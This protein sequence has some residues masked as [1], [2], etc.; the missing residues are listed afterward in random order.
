MSKK[1]IVITGSAGQL[2]QY[3]VQYFSSDV[4]KGNLDIYNTVGFDKKDVDIEDYVKVQKYFD[5]VK[6]MC[7]GD[8]Y[9]IHCAAATDTAAIE[10]DP[11]KFYSTNCLGAKN[12]A[13][14]AHE[15]GAKL[16]YISTDYIFSE[17]SKPANSGLLPFPMNQYGVQKLLAEQFV[18]EV[19]A[20]NLEDLLIF[21][22]SWMFGNSH[23]SFIEKFL[24]NVFKKYSACVN[25]DNQTAGIDVEVVDDAYGKPTPVWYIADTLR[26]AIAQN[27]CGTIDAMEETTQIS[28]F[29]WAKMIWQLFSE[30][31]LDM[32]PADHPLLADVA[33]MHEQVKIV[34]TLSSTLNLTMHHP[35]LINCV[36]NTT[37]DRTNVNNRP[38]VIAYA[39]DLMKY[40]DD[41][42]EQL[43]GIAA[44]VLNYPTGN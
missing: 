23:T 20:D 24:T 19:Y 12:I 8:V 35:G 18:K 43:L 28:R 25:N 5:D 37:V 16:I 30:H 29:D 2:G 36:G 31:K 32:L 41:N 15:I 33:K 40:I 27:A 3:L 10:K 21:R 22:S 13:F 38:Y 11:N 6:A 9:V 44:Q 4:V 14:S 17:N 39:Y 1:T 26:D 7:K 34:P 42:I